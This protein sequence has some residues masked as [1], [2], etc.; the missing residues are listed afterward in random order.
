MRNIYILLIVLL[1]TGCSALANGNLKWFNNVDKAIE[2][3]LKEENINE[4]DLIDKVKENGELF[5]FYKKD[6][7]DGPGLGV[8]TVSEKDGKYTWFRTDKDVLL[9]VSE[10][11]W[12]TKTLSD[13][14]FVIY[15]GT[16]KNENI[17]IETR[18][19]IVNPIIDKK[20]G[21]YYYVESIGK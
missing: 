4:Q 15:T 1:T 11:S 19:G 10:I 7:K 12:E 13:K 20:N 9:N 2:Y 21:I 17:E 8:S 14:K 6:L 18:K 16:T 3:G 5:I